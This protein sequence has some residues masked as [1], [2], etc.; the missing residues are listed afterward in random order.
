MSVSRSLES[1][2]HGFVKF[3]MSDGHRDDVL[4]Y[5]TG[6]KGQSHNV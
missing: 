4:M 2:S 3:A 6:R 1:S 5:D